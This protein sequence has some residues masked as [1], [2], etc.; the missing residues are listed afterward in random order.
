MKAVFS[1]FEYASTKRVSL[2]DR[3]LREIDAVSP[4]SALVAKI[5]SGYLKNEGQGSPPSGLLRIFGMYLAQ[6]CLMPFGTHRI[7]PVLLQNRLMLSS[8][9]PNDQ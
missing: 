9:V 5:E 2:R 7:R 1:D 8:Q 3:I 6:Q 4:W